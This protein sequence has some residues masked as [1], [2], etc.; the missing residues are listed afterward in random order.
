MTLHE[1]Q[2][3]LEALPTLVRD[4]PVVLTRRHKPVL[5]AMS[6]THFEAMLETLDIL[7]DRPFCHRLAKSIWEV[8]EGRTLDAV[9]VRDRL[10]L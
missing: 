7:S 2:R 10:G 9:T 3:N 1:A 6:Y 4:S 8:Q 5:V